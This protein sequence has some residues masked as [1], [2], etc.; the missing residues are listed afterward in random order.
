MA[1]VLR[2]EQIVEIKEAFGLFHKDGDGE[3]ESFLL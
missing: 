1:E 2:A 3:W